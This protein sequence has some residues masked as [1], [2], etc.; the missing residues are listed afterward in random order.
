MDT[1]H[2]DPCIC[3]A[4]VPTNVTIVTMATGVT[5]VHW[6]QWLCGAPQLLCSAVNISWLVLLQ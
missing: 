1:L 2:E 6:V 3:M 4:I 5:T